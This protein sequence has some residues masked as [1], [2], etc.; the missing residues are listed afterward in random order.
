VQLEAAHASRTVNATRTVNTV[1][2]WYLPSSC[3]GRYKI[4]AGFHFN[5]NSGVMP[6]N[7]NLAQFLKLS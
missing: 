5:G 6:V 4:T 1:H 3:R 7:D 2:F